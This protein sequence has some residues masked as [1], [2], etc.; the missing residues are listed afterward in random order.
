MVDFSS[1]LNSSTDDNNNNDENKLIDIDNV[2]QVSLQTQ[3]AKR[4]SS[5][6]RIEEEDEEDD[7][8]VEGVDSPN[9]DRPK[10]QSL[11]DPDDI[12]RA[13]EDNHALLRVSSSTPSEVFDVPSVSITKFEDDFQDTVGSDLS[14]IDYLRADNFDENG[15]VSSNLSTHDRNEILA[16]STPILLDTDFQIV[17]ND[18]PTNDQTEFISMM[19]SQ[20]PLIQLVLG[21]DRTYSF[22]SRGETRCRSSS[23]DEDL[24]VLRE[25]SK[26]END[27]NHITNNDLLETQ[28]DHESSFMIS[29]LKLSE[30]A[31]L[32]MKDFFIA[33]FFGNIIYD[34]KYPIPFLLSHTLAFIVGAFVGR[35]MSINTPQNNAFFAQNA[36]NMN[37][38]PNEM[39]S[40]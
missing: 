34:Q 15:I 2:T 25:N 28:I 6:F 14:K 3:L 23:A 13:L 20:A 4:T 37:P 17:Q 35:K 21:K 29:I 1:K 19:S 33:V 40:A 32:K 16:S 10:L 31:C 38:Q 39:A 7:V 8:E 12:N 26:F 30:S 18:K 36:M 5:Y 24:A 11:P 27:F 22:T 9:K